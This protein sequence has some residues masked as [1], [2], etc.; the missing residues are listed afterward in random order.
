MSPLTREGK[1][2]ST[3][4]LCARARK[5]IT[6]TPM[7]CDALRTGKVLTVL[8]ASDVSANTG[9]RLTSKCAYY[10][11]PLYRITA[12]TE[13]LA[14]A[15]GKTGSLAAVGLTDE[16]FV[17]AITPHLPKADDTVNQ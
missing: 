5:L 14:R 12:D 4:G 11:V 17:R 15:V 7:V 8:M 2:L 3:V 6:G 16:Q 1:L 10:G 9:D 13:R